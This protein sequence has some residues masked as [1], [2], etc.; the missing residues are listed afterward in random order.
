M[1]EER[2]CSVTDVGPGKARRFELGD[3]SVAVVRI[4][5]GWYAIGDRC[6]HEDVS[7][8][9]VE[10]LGD[11]AEIECSKHGSCF[12]LTDGQPSCLPATKPVPVYDIRVDGDDVYLVV[13]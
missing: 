2:L 8:S 10:V 13:P 4:G 6:S 1:T 12:S 3:L 5:D 9:E 11:T 7:L